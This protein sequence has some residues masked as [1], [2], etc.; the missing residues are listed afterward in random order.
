MER[1]NIAK[2]LKGIIFIFII[3]YIIIFW[4]VIFSSVNLKELSQNSLFY[5]SGKLAGLT[6]FLFLSFLIFSGETARFFDR[7]FG[8]NKIILFQRKFALITALFVISHPIFFILSTKS[9]SYLIPSFILTPLTFGIVSFYLFIIIMISS[10]LYKRISYKIWQYL[11]ILIYLLFFFSLY[12]AIKIGS[13]SDLLP[14]KSI[15]LTAL[16]SILIG[17]VYRTFY[18]IKQRV[19]EKFFLKEI[20]KETEDTF[21]LILETKK[22]FSFKAGQFCFLRLKRKGIYA[23]HPISISSFP[24]EENLMFTIKLKGRFTKEAL[25]LKIGEEI[26]VEGPFGI[27]T[28]DDTIGRNKDKNLI[29]IA[30]GVGITPFFSMIKS[31]LHLDYGKTN[32][33]LQV[34]EIASQS[35]VFPSSPKPRQTPHFSVEY[36][37]EG[38]GDIKRNIT[39]FYCS[40]TIKGTIFK[41]ELDKIKENWLKNIYIMSEDVYQGNVNETGI[42]NKELIKKYLDEEKIKNSVFYICG[43]EKMKECATKEL[44]E[45]GIKK[46]NI[47]IEDFFW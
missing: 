46:E 43:P 13:D 3:Y 1:E 40:K 24:D 36:K 7:F 37:T 39:L 34:G 23:R 35:A 32:S 44:K 28:I 5:L 31:N 47:I 11:H 18:K 29:F 41:K 4:N 26:I 9:F 20:K 38:F 21:T 2:I 8:I 42:I 30:G 14:I 27:F 12:H 10:F 25:N 6:G 22:N 33:N 15:Y 16:I 17:L 45:L 19:S